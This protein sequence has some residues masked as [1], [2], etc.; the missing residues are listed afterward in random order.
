MGD[1]AGINGVMASETTLNFDSDVETG[2][3]LLPMSP[4]VIGTRAVLNLGAQ[5]CPPR[6]YRSSV[7]K[8]QSKH[9]SRGREKASEAH[10]ACQ[11]QSGER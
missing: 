6:L 10:T 1:T 3:N 8:T 9:A 4:G 7:C 2:R 11:E 5:T